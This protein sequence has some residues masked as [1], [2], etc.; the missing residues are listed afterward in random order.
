[1]PDYNY[2][3]CAYFNN[4]TDAPKEHHKNSYSIR[5]YIFI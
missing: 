3:D 4:I 1:M 5:N 2:V